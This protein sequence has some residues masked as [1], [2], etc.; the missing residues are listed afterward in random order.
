[1]TPLDIAAAFVVILIWAF[2]FVAAK[3]GVT[4]IPALMLLGLRFTLVAFLLLPFL[5][6]PGPRWRL[7]IAVSIV[8]GGFH[9]GLMFSGLQGV[10]AGPAAIAIQLTVPFSAILAWVFYRER[11]GALQLVGLVVAFVGVYILAGEPTTKPSVPHFLMVV[12]GAFA[13]ALANV[14]IKRIGPIDVFLLNGWLAIFAAPQLFLASMLLEEGQV[15]AVTVADWRAWGSVAF[16][17]IGASITAYGLWYYLIR[18]YEMNKVV[19]LMLLSPV[20]AVLLA[21][22]LL[23]EPLTLRIVLGGAIT[24]TGV[25]MIQFLKSARPRTAPQP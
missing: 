3:I 11:M 7:V 24:I 8:L 5:R 10:D 16:M 25:A 6:W 22:A 13:W 17:A 9:F 21:A 23:G 2:N 18:K 4:Q 14:I 19:P 20:L 1:M 12:A 15:A